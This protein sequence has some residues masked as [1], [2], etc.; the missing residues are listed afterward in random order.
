MKKLI[1]LLLALTMA[2]SLCACGGNSA[3]TE[4][5]SDKEPA[6]EN[7]SAEQISIEKNLAGFWMDQF[8]Q[9]ASG[10]QMLILSYYNFADGSVL[11][12]VEVMDAHSEVKY[13]KSTA[14]GTY[15][16][17]DSSINITWDKITH[18][19]EDY[20]IEPYGELPYT[21]ED[22]DIFHLFV[23]DGSGTELI[24]QEKTE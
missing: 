2:L 18:E 20:R 21:Y 9:E 6:E 19:N 17:G 15:E 22:A 8:I 5:T 11:G 10:I 3:P 12:G 23:G 14:I 1:T 4:T 24:R 13:A 7:T 16:V